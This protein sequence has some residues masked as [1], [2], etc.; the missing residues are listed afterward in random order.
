MN[1]YQIDVSGKIYK[2]S[3]NLL[4]TIPYF[5]NMIKDIGD[6]DDKYIF[7]ERSSLLFDHVYAYVIDKLHPYPIEYYY[8][9]DFYGI[10][11]EKDKLYDVNLV[12]KNRLDI[13]ENI[14]ININ[15][16]TE[17]IVD[18]TSGFSCVIQECKNKAIKGKLSC[19]K[20][21]NY[22]RC[23]VP[24]C[25]KSATCTNFCNKHAL[26]EYSGCK[27]KSCANDRI[28]GKGFC[29]KHFNK[30]NKEDK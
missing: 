27:F 25:F 4:I 30:D 3:K 22:D 21:S 6:N 16:H 19:C 18:T 15:K 1:I 29:F 11:Y 5:A 8:E 14:N 12:I 28:P 2:I 26:I 9:L 20:H 17:H 13:V 24:N 7:V 10:E 23:I